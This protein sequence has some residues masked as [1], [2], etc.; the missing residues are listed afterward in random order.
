MND[1]KIKIMSK[2]NY[3]LIA[4]SSLFSIP[5]LYGIYKSN[6][7]LA[8][9]TT[10]AMLCSI[11]Y[12]MNPVE[13]YYKN[14]DLVVS[15]ISGVY[16]FI[17]GVYNINNQYPKLF[18]YANMFMMLSCYN[19]SCLLYKMNSPSWVKFHVGFHIFIITGKL[20]VL[21]FSK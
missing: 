15:K 9:M 18:G 10:S 4:S 17:Y 13:G 21:V 1:N 19:A 8:T 16:Y 5:L 6:W 3:S 7:I 11:K 2:P 14:M 20:I 12:W